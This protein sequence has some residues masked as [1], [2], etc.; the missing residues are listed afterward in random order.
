MVLDK[1]MSVEEAKESARNELKTASKNYL[2]KEETDPVLQVKA[3]IRELLQMRINSNTYFK[4][5]ERRRRYKEVEYDPYN[6]NYANVP[7]M[8]MV[9]PKNSI[10]MPYANASEMPMVGPKNSNSMPSKVGGRKSRKV[11]K[12]KNRKNKSRRH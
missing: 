4:P 1:I 3:P 12:N 10:S 2:N 5:E 6:D 7:Q 11:R 9:G 8:P